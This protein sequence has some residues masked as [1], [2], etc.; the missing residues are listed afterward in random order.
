MATAGLAAQGLTDRAAIVE[1][2]LAA[3]GAPALDSVRSL[4]VEKTITAGAYSAEQQLYLLTSGSAL[5]RTESFG[6]HITMAIDGRSGDA[7]QINPFTDASGNPAD[8]GQAERGQLQM[9]LK[10]FGPFYRLPADT[11]VT[12]L[13][14]KKSRKRTHYVLEI[15]YPNAFREKIFL[16][17]ETFLIAKVVNSFGT[18]FFEDYRTEA[19]VTLPRYAEI[20]GPQGTMTIRTSLVRLNDRDIT[21]ELFAR[22]SK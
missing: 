3:V 19:G 15:T 12:Y 16:D 18:T 17:A 7:W 6:Q 14:T 1:K 2:H 9:Q 20:N 5:A 13:E 11:E 22:P 8:L 4:Y 10:P 21:P